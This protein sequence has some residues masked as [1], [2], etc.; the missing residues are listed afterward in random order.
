MQCISGRQCVWLAAALTGL[1]AAACANAEEL[2][3][4]GYGGRPGVEVTAGTGG[5]TAQ[6]TPSAVGASGSGGAVSQG[7]TSQGA[8]SGAGGYGG[9]G[10]GGSGGATSA[11]AG[12]AG[13]ISSSLDAGAL[14]ATRD[15]PIR[16]EAGPLPA[17]VALLYKATDTNPSDSQLAPSYELT[18]M[19]SST[20]SLSDFKVRYYLTNEAK[21]MLLSDYLYAEVNGGAGYRDI[22]ANASLVIAP[23]SPPKGGADTLVD[24]VFS[25]A[26]GT[27]AP[28]QTSRIDFTVHTPGFATNLNESDDYSHDITKTDFGANDKVTLFYQDN[29]VAGVEP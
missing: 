22:R 29:L 23:L 10:G 3:T 4:P 1:A 15:A 28:G 24:L 14:D 13:G 9:A 8:T 27:L 7:A 19:G 18:N 20:L 11:G 2:E 17:G 21:I 12:G 16:T 26:A 25:T 5:S 6:G